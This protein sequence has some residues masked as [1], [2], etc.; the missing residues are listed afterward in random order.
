MSYWEDVEADYIAGSMFYEQQ[1]ERSAA[2]KAHQNFRNNIWRTKDNREIAIKDMD[3]SH[4]LNAYKHS[5]RGDLF[6]EMVVRLFESRVKGG[7]V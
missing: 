2:Q 5:G 1:Q 3:D 6:K 4:L 7:G